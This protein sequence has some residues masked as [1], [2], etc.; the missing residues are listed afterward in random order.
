MQRYS[1]K[2][3]GSL[4]VEACMAFPVFLCFFLLLLFC[5]KFACVSLTLDLAV[6]ETAKQIAALAYPIKYLNTFEDDII[7][8]YGSK[9]IPT[10]EEEL[11]KLPGYAG[12]EDP[13]DAFADILTGN[14]PQPDIKGMAGKIASDYMEGVVGN[15]VNHGLDAYW[16]YKP[17]VKYRIAKVLI[18]NFADRGLINPQNIRFR[19][20]EFPQSEHEYAVRKDQ[21]T[22]LGFGG[23]DITRDD[24]VVQIE[25]RFDVPLP[26]FGSK[27]IRMVHTAVEKAWLKGSYGVITERKE[28]LDIFETAPSTIVY[29]T[30]T[31]KRYH[32]GSCR[33]LYASK[34]PM[35]L[36]QAALKYTPCKVCKPPPPPNK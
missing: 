32:L 16:E 3:R 25:Y 6:N 30:R 13:D 9:Q 24:V 8:E 28:G 27:D 12:L 36:S 23:A 1:N 5:V 10:I 21:Y 22:R 7:E 17:G 11:G 33:Y 4:T 14:L 31:G 29:V 26:F 19:L 15:L 2:N 34:I 18:D 35:P 20:V